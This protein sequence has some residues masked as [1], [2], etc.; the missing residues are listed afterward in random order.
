MYETHQIVI[1][2]RTAWIALLGSWVM[3]MN[4]SCIILLSIS[5]I[6]LSIITK[7]KYV[8]CKNLLL[9][10]CASTSVM[11]I[12]QLLTVWLA[13]S[14]SISVRYVFQQKTFPSNCSFRAKRK[15]RW[16]LP[17]I[18]FSSAWIKSIKNRYIIRSHKYA[19]FLQS[20]LS[21]LSEFGW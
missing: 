19:I 1:A 11:Y 17:K 16:H 2:T 9:N 15:C 4:L 20:C 10:K 21:G 18:R 14:Y 8:T 12:N 13:I 7:E 5:W 6:N 3:I